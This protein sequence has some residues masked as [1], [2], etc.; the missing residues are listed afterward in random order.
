MNKYFIIEKQKAAFE[1]ILNRKLELERERLV[2]Y[3]ATEIDSERISLTLKPG[4]TTEGYT[5]SVDDEE[6]WKIDTFYSFPFFARRVIASKDNQL[7]IFAHEFIGESGAYQAATSESIITAGKESTM[8]FCD[9]HLMIPCSGLVKGIDHEN[10]YAQSFT[11]CL[12]QCN[13]V[14][15]SNNYVKM[16]ERHCLGEYYVKF[17]D[18]DELQPCLVTSSQHTQTELT[19]VDIVIMN[20]AIN[21]HKLLEY[22]RGNFLQIVDKGKTLSLNELIEQFQ[23]KICGETRNIVFS[24]KDV[25]KYDVVKVLASEYAPMGTLMGKQMLEYAEE[26]IAQYDTAVCHVSPSTLFEINRKFNSNITERLASQA[27]EIF[28]IEL[29]LLQDAAIHKVTNKVREEFEQLKQEKN[30]SLLSLEAL[31]IDVLNSIQFFNP[32]NFM[33]PTVRQSFQTIGNRFGLDKSWMLYQDSK[34]SLEQLISIKRIRRE[35]FENK[36]LNIVLLILTLVQIIPTLADCFM[37]IFFKSIEF[38][39]LISEFSASLMGVLLCFIIYAIN[40]RRK[41]AKKMNV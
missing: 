12:K 10:E 1:K 26:N 40:R 13:N 39:V 33:F 8:P 34:N 25:D 24:S 27:I 31:S 30:D 2:G 20:V 7:P 38:K 16:L 41:N 32:N 18:S 3:K 28:F 5:F 9:V 11:E 19:I 17:S 29:I 35:E 21:P 6:L 14:E 23:L 4:D 36:V 22:F 15:F 37:A